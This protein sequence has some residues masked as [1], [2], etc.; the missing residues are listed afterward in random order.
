LQT[1][2]E[3]ADPVN[4]GPLL[5]REPAEGEVARP[6]FQSEG[7]VDSYAPPPTIEGFATS[8]GGDLITPVIQ[9]VPGLD[10]R[11]SA[12]VAPPLTGNRSGTTVVLAQYTQ[13]AGSDGHFVVFDVPAAET[14]SSEF[15]GTLA[16]TGQATVVA[17]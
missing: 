17:P 12:Q 14:Q 3:R 7:F 11:G 2:I 13:S 16:S 8:I 9:D 10:L 15:L 5:S 1:W 6:I 4:Y